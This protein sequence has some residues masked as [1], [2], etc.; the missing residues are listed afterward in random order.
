[1]KKI[2]ERYIIDIWKSDDGWWIAEI[3]LGEHNWATQG[4]NEEEIWDM[5]ADSV[6]CVKDTPTYWWNN[7]LKRLLVYFKS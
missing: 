4:R 3:Q 5:V 7:L 6:L 1:M 2:K